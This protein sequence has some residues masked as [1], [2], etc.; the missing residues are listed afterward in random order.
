[1]RILGMDLSLNHSGFVE[2]DAKGKVTWYD[3]VTDTKSHCVLGKGTH[4][5][6][7]KLPDR[8]QVAMERLVWWRWRFSQILKERKPT[9]VGIEDY[10][11]RAEGNS[12]Y[13][14]GEQGGEARLA[15]WT[16]GAALRLHDPL[17]VKM[18]GALNGVATPPELAECIREELAMRGE[19]GDLFSQHHPPKMEH[20]A[21]KNSPEYDLCSAYTLA[22]LVYTEL[23]LREGKLRLSSLPPKQVQVFQRVTKSYP[24]NL[25]G[26]EWL[27]RTTVTPDMI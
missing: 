14:I 7:S 19:A 21:G 23:L 16:A 15:V 26:R 6:K 4:F 24:I 27:K 2:L 9:H 20:G 10:A 11:I 12:I 1:M 17:S 22:R 3:Y 13:Q 25:L 18:F 8:Q 5:I